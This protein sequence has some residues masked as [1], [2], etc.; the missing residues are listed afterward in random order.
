MKPFSY[1]TQSALF[2]CSQASPSLGS[3]AFAFCL[4]CSG[5][6]FHNHM[7]RQA[8]WID[9]TPFWRYTGVF[10]LNM[11]FL[12]CALQSNFIHL[13]ISG[14]TSSPMFIYCPSRCSA[15]WPQ[16][17]C[18]YWPPCLLLSICFAWVSFYK[19]YFKAYFPAYST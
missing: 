18:N 7:W 15:R 6:M 9:Q 10:D 14:M 4:D 13:Y 11:E 5:S 8:A 17:L 12:E 19:F 3:W 16:C 1:C 2:L